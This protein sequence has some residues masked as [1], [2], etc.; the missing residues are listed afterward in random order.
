MYE[1]LFKEQEALLEKQFFEFLQFASISADESFRPEIKACAKWLET[2]LKDSGF[3]VQL[4]N[5]EGAPVVFAE[6]CKKGKDAPTILIYN[7]YDVQPVDPIELWE[8]KPFTPTRK[9]NSIVAR[10]AQDNKGQCFYV[11]A[12]LRALYTAHGQF[13]VNIKLIIEGEEESGSKSLPK[14][15]EEKKKELEAD[16][17]LVVDVGMQNA[18]TPA[19]TLGTRGI[20]TFTVE[21]SSSKSDLH[22]GMQGGVVYNPLHALV[23]ILDTL[24]DQDGKIT[25]PE[26]YSE[27]TTPS[28][29]ELKAISFTFSDEEFE[30]EFGCMATGG[31]KGYKPLERCWLRPTLEING[32]NGGYSGPGFKTV[33]P[34]KAVAKISC[35]LVP[36]QEPHLIGKRVKQFIESQ[37]KPGFKVVCHVH[38]GSGKPV[39]TSPNSPLVKALADASERVYHNKA[40]YIY[41]GGSI[42][43]VTELAKAADADVCFFG[44]GLAS[45]KIHAPNENFSWDRIQNGFVIMCEAIC[46][47]A[48]PKG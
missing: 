24:R 43:I 42:P 17:L 45:D 27:V 20:I 1:K 35:R 44:L 15:L 8:S 46:R 38:E 4:W 25:V 9:G 11:I 30:K 31:E 37:E 3:E 12:A 48:N 23:T 29:D 33:I 36:D 47:L 6:N 16:Y 2:Y 41:E 22:S 14:V 5:K 34:A 7:H 21:V 32:I 19:I 26:F 13:P 39:R 28:Q 10:G 40:A 18:T